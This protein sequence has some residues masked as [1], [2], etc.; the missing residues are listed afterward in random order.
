MRN[1]I[2][3]FLVIALLSQPFP[4]WSM[5]SVSQ[6]DGGVVYLPR[7]TQTVKGIK[8]DVLTQK[9]ISQTNTVYIIQHDCL[10]T[11]DLVMPANSTLRFEGGSLTGSFSRKL[12]L[13]GCYIDGDAKFRDVSFS[14]SIKNGEFNVL[15]IDNGDL[16]ERINKANENFQNL[17]VPA[18][19]YVFNTPVNVQVK[20][21]RCEGNL[22]YAGNYINNQGVFIVT[23]WGAYVHIAGLEPYDRAKIDYSDKR[24][25]NAVGLEIRSCNNSEIHLDK[26]YYFNENLRISDLNGMGCCYNKFFLGVIASG[27]YN[28]RLYQ[29][30][31]N[32]GKI[33]WV[34]ENHFFGGRLTHWTDSR[35]WGEYYNVGV[36][37]PA[38]DK[39][40]FRNSG[41][42]DHEDTCNG[43]TFV[44]TSIETDRIS[45]LFRNVTDS[46][47][48]G[49]R[50]ESSP[51]F[52]KIIGSFERI[53]YVPKFTD[54]HS[55]LNSDFSEATT[56]S[57]TNY[58]DI[59]R[60]ERSIVIDN[61]VTVDNKLVPY[62]G[63]VCNTT[64]LK[65]IS[66]K[67][68]TQV[69]VLLPV[70]NKK[71]VCASIFLNKDARVYIRLLD[72]NNNNITDKYTSTK[73]GY[74]LEYYPNHKAFVS[75]A[76]VVGHQIHIPS[77]KGRIA[78][79]FVG[80]EAGQGIITTV[81]S[82]VVV[83]TP[84]ILTKGPS[85][86]RPMGLPANVTY[87]DTDLRMPIWWDGKRWIDAT[88]KTVK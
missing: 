82:D 74:Q 40:S 34:N 67:Y 66:N 87:F 83:D 25:T 57:F 46:Q 10:L 63:Y 41:V 24:K 11:D 53:Y 52:A 13:N 44:G 42:N 14:G 78:K 64:S 76:D 85:S 19:D 9:M 68:L 59:Y 22:K 21:L 86:M 7:N 60:L 62:S 79:V 72:S 17:Y 75:T 23:G 70:G 39:P 73:I 1:V 88:G 35:T 81:Y 6:S 33:S 20:S 38:I 51:G 16:G 54:I 55:I 65:E 56:L 48:I 18:G 4:C 28:I 31:T 58:R 50:Q 3:S 80:C 15:W 32:D 12:K 8:R 71:D 43:L 69:G 27:N 49:M 26:I 29:Q 61:S 84:S 5:C 37:G 30:D 2:G 45:L 77:P 47:F 36:G